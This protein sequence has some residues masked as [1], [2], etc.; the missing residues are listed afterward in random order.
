LVGGARV[1]TSSPM[2]NL[3]KDL[4]IWMRMLLQNPEFTAI[5]V[6]AFRRPVPR[7]RSFRG[8]RATKST[9]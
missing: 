8:R 7:R 4:S 3:L 9:P 5:A 1:K 2:N 6:P